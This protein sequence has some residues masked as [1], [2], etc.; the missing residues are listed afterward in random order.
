MNE[1]PHAISCRSTRSMST[2]TCHPHTPAVHTPARQPDG[3]STSGREVGTWQFIW[4]RNGIPQRLMFQVWVRV[5]VRGAGYC[6]A[7]GCGLGLMWTR[8]GCATNHVWIQNRS[9]QEQV[10]DGVTTLPISVECL[11]SLSIDDCSRPVDDS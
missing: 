8:V 3:T 4:K 10:A 5:K 9:I 1:A 2:H 6:I 7:P 11:T